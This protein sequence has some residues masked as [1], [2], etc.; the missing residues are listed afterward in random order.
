[1]MSLVVNASLLS[2]EINFM[3]TSSTLL[4]ASSSI[5]LE[6][7]VAAHMV[8]PR[9]IASN[10][11]CKSFPSSDCWVLLTSSLVNSQSMFAMLEYF[12]NQ[13]A[14]IFAALIFV[15]Y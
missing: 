9:D 3:T 6:I 13:G 10:I 5:I 7:D 4:L 14:S 1:M 11:A 15:S 12:F 2:P 8:L